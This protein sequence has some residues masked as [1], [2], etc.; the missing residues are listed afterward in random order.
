MIDYTYMLC[1]IQLTQIDCVLHYAVSAW[2]INKYG[3]N[4]ARRSPS[5]SN[6]SRAEADH[7]PRMCTLLLKRA[8]GA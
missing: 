7:A 4:P 8:G 3:E 5:P 2:K 1:H 6:S